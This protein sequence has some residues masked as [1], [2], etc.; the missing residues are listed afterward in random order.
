MGNHKHRLALGSSPRAWIAVAAIAATCFL[1]WLGLSAGQHSAADIELNLATELLG[2]VVT[3]A[4]IEFF[5]ERSRQRETIN[6]MSFRALDELDHAVWVWLGGSRALDCQELLSLLDR[7]TDDDPL[8]EFTQN[9]FLRIG[10]RADHSLVVDSDKVGASASLQRA[11]SQ[12]G[13][14]CAMRDG[15]SAMT[16]SQIA[17]LSRSATTELMATLGWPQP[18]SPI[19]SSTLKE[20]SERAQRWRHFGESS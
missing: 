15:P 20:S 9:L 1:I 8:P 3:V 13:K 16:P 2:I 10:S 5:F 12:L 18:Q 19:G 17:S 4:V 11:L 14:L 6:K 7:V